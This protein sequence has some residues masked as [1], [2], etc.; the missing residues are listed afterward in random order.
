[1]AVA[2]SRGDVELLS[3]R[4]GLTAG[5]TV[6]AVAR[7]PERHL[8]GLFVVELVFADQYQPR[9]EAEPEGDGGAKDRPTA[10]AEAPP[11]ARTSTAR[12]QCAWYGAL[13]GSSRASARRRADI[14]SVAAVGAAVGPPWVVVPVGTLAA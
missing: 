12:C 14:A 13:T 5:L 9:V 11:S 1:M 3:A 6:R 10:A 2:A 7:E 4:K 8:A